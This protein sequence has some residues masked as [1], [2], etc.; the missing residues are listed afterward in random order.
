[1]TTTVSP[2][3]PARP[4]AHTSDEDLARLHREHGRALFRFL[5]GLTHGDAQRAEDL[6]QETMIRAWRHPEA[7]TSEHESMRPWL[8]TVARRLAIDARR[9]RLAR[10]EECPHGLDGDRLE[11]DDPIEPSIEVLD[12]RAALKALSSR[13]HA[14]V[15]QVYFCGRS[16]SEAAEALGVPPGTVKSRSHYAL[17]A[18]RRALRDYDTLG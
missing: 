5:T 13:H 10:V 14:V 12:V 8:F 2:G 18:L 11:A 16:V 17:R 6:V 15:Q 7:L 9:A 4:T 1:M 3:T